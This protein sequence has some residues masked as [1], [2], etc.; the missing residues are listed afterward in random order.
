MYLYIV[1]FSNLHINISIEAK[2]INP[3]YIKRE[4]K[5]NYYL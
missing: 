2:H 5:K 1:F 3:I 4:V